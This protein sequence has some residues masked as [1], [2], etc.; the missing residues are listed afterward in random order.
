MELFRKAS[1]DCNPM[2]T[3]KEYAHKTAFGQPVVFGVLAAIAAV[4]RIPRQSDHRPTKITLDFPGA[5]FAEVNYTVQVTTMDEHRFMARILDG[6]NIMLTAEVKYEPSSVISAST[7][8]TALFER[9]EPALRSEDE[10]EEGQ[11]INGSYCP[12]GEALAA[13][14]EKYDLKSSGFGTIELGALCWA[15]YCVGMELP[16]RNA[17]FGRLI[18]EFDTKRPAVEW[19]LQYQSKI[20][21]NDKR[22]DL[23]RC[24][25][26][27]FSKGISIARAG[28]LSFVRRE[29]PSLDVELI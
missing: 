29:L 11:I 5:L 20:I 9:S 8:P 13:L 23:V 18:I 16:G 21:A 15:S 6:S 7:I 3:S 2:H 27:L 28:L 22:F 4:S 14:I 10:L 24:E 25:A 12:Y 19:P 1:G 26:Q 17:L